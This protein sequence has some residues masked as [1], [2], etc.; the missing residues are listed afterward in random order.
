MVQGS[1]LAR[2]AVTRAEQMAGRSVSRQVI[3][4][5][6]HSHDG[7]QTWHDHKG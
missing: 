5:G 1:A 4:Q 3:G 6:A 2:A 7:G